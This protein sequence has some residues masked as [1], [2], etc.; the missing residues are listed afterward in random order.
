MN[1]ELTT[2]QSAHL[3]WLKRQVNNLK[4]EQHT[5]NQRPRL[6]QELFEAREEL[7]DYI[8]ILKAAGKKL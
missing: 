8:R 1:E 3:R 4:D 7:D 6:E 2:F 5:K